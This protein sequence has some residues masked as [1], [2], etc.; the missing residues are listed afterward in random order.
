MGINPL[1]SPAGVNQAHQLADGFPTLVIGGPSRVSVSVGPE[2][3]RPIGATDDEHRV[4]GREVHRLH[5]PA[6]HDDGRVA[7]RE[8]VG[9]ERLDGAVD[10]ADRQR[11][12][13]P[14]TNRRC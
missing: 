9:V 7:Y 14:A 13:R 3:K 4:V 6:G 5:V 11:A 1:T 12:P 2:R 10:R 8:R